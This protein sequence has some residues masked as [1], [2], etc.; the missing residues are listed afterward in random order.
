VK[1]RTAAALAALAIIGSWPIC[2]CERPPLTSLQ[3]AKQAIESA[4]HAGATRYAEPDYRAAEMLVSSGWVEIGRQNGRLPPFRNYAVAESVLT[5]ATRMANRAAL[6]SQERSRSLESLAH[7]EY[8]SL[9]RYL[10]SYR[11]ELDGTL[12]AY[13]EQRYWSRASL[14]LQTASRLIGRG[15]FEDARTELG[16]GR[17]ALKQL[18]EIMQVRRAEEDGQ[19]ATWRSWVSE[20]VGGTRASG[21]AAI[22]VVKTDHQ[23]YLVRG[24]RLLERYRCDLSYNSAQQKIGAGDFATPE[25]R[26]HVVAVKGRSRYYKALEINYPNAED[27]A[28]FEA[29]KRRGDLRKTARIGGLIEIHG[30]GG[31]GRDWT[32]G[33]VALANGDMDRLLRYVSVG[34]PVT[35]VR[36]CGNWP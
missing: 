27:R 8:A 34:T 2:G 29:A 35:I 12:A 28:R 7:S 18:A 5:Q 6:L 1:S 22:V 11:Q 14:S 33:C 10:A 36:R 16:R 19:L 21:G 30:E 23:L 15:E 4:S 24:G 20:T 26:Y 3:T 13:R 31:N 17:L 32:M 25:G 9:E